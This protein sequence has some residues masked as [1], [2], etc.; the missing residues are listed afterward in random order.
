[1]VSPGDPVPEVWWWA[2][3]ARPSA[4]ASSNVRVV[5]SRSDRRT[6]SPGAAHKAEAAAEGAAT[7]GAGDDSRVAEG[8][9]SS[10]L[11]PDELT[12]PTMVGATFTHDR[13]Q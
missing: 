11:L 5:V 8:S 10:L 9:S 6:L 2:R 7:E 4:Y 13:D 1:M 12:Q 3:T